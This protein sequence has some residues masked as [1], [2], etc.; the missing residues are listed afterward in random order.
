MVYGKRELFEAF[1]RTAEEEGLECIV[2][3]IPFKNDDVP[4]YLASLR[5]FRRKSRENKSGI[6]IGFYN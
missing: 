1:R 5:E 4:R 2:K 3:E 6:I